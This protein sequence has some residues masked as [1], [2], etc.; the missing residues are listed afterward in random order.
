M[1][2]Q[3]TVS[4][5][6]PKTWKKVD[7]I[8]SVEKICQSLVCVRSAVFQA[9]FFVRHSVCHERCK[10]R[11]CCRCVCAFQ[12]HENKDL[13]VFCQPDSAHIPMLFTIA[14]LLTCLYLGSP[15]LLPIFSRHDPSMLMHLYACC[16]AA[17]RSL[18]ALLLLI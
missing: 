16:L 11:T 13:L 15:G 18:V 4:S 2:F 9:V 8:S 5:V 6:Q 10:Q 14:L 7:P 3:H 17:V 12:R 1:M